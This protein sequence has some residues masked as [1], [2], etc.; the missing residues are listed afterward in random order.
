MASAT[1]GSYSEEV[2]PD[3]YKN[4]AKMLL[5]VMISIAN[6]MSYLLGLTFGDSLT[7]YWRVALFFP[8]IFTVIRLICFTMI[9]RYESP[10]WVLLQYTLD[11]HLVNE[12]AARKKIRTIFKKI[13]RND[14]VEDVLERECNIFKK[15]VMIFKPS[16]KN[17]FFFPYK[18]RLFAGI[19]LA[20]SQQACGSSL[21]ILYSTDIF[22]DIIGYNKYFLTSL[23]GLTNFMGNKNI[24]FFLI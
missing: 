14:I 23:V 12:A 6:A 16:L 22:D 13:Y 17:M 4:L 2:I 11:N 18:F 15:T 9:Y 10:R 8:S 20:I 1:I 7:T 21:L 19:V 24:Y 5:Y 3:G